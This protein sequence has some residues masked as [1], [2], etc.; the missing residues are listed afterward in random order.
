MCW[1]PAATARVRDFPQDSMDWPEM[2]YIR[3]MEM[4]EKPERLQSLMVSAACSAEWMRPRATSSLL[5]KDCTP[6]E[7]RLKPPFTRAFISAS[8][9]TPG[10]VSR[11]ISAS[12]STSK[13]FLI[14]FRMELSRSA[15][16][17]VGVPPPK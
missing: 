7:T 5:E 9:V 15:P 13:H 17:R 11:V 3:S 4:L 16:R 12:S 2:P 1:T 8:L 6:M 14:Y 10:L